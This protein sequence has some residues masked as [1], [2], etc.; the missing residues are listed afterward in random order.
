MRPQGY[1]LSGGKSLRF[2]SDKARHKTNSQSLIE[3]LDDKLSHWT[4]HKSIAVADRPDKYLD[5]NIP[6]I[7]DIHPDAGPLAGLHAALTHAQN[8]AE[9]NWIMLI[10]CDMTELKP[11]WLDILW[12][13][14]QQTEN[15]LTIHFL[16]KD[17]ETSDNRLHPFPG[18]Y[19]ISLIP[20]IEAQLTNQ[21]RSFYKLFKQLDQNCHSLPIPADWPEIPQ[22]NTPQE[23]EVWRKTQTE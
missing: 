17:S 13:H 11:D 3:N 14:A 7:A 9:L 16:E 19:H 1:I 22:I 21:Q 20:I 23:S 8:S 12:N 18:L 2:G 6:T 4:S 5:L 15:A 10:S